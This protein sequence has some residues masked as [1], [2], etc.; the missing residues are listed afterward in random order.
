[1]GYFEYPRESNASEVAAA[2]DIEPSTF[3]Q[4]LNAAQT[5]L[6]DELLRRE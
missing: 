5:K 1:M 4:H 6:L 2:L 3:T